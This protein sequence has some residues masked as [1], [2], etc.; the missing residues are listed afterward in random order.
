MTEYQ[1]TIELYALFSIFSIVLKGYTRFIY[2]YEIW[3]GSNIQLR[4]ININIDDVDA[5]HINLNMTL[6][7]RAKNLFHYFFSLSLSIY[8]N[9]GWD[10][11][12]TTYTYLAIYSYT[13]VIEIICI[14]IENVHKT[15]STQSSTICAQYLFE[16]LL[17]VIGACSIDPKMLMQLSHHR[18][19]T[20]FFCQY[21]SLFSGKLLSKNK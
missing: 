14:G 16:F 20:T 13:T 21:F 17:I 1:T 5:L 11:S 7:I 9:V 19:I 6:M 10:H 12:H 8:S 15:I 18:N 2:L 3:F 4:G